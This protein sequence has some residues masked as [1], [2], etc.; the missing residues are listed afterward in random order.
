[1]NPSRVS[2]LALYITL[3]VW[4]RYA[5]CGETELASNSNVGLDAVVDK[6]D[7]P[8]GSWLPVPIPISNPTVGTGLQGVLLYL[9]PAKPGDSASTPNATSGLG[10]MYTSTDSKVV[11]LFHDDYFADD[12]YRFKALAGVGDLNLN[13]Y[14]FGDFIS[15]DKV[16]Y[17]I[18]PK[19]TFIE[20][21]RRLPWSNNGYLG[22]NHLYTS[23]ELK[24]HWK[25]DLE[26][27]RPVD[28]PPIKLQPTTSSLGLI[29][30]Y[31]SRDDTYYPTA[32]SNTAIKLTRDKEQWGS[33]FD[34]QRLSLNFRKY[35]ALWQKHVLA[36]RATLSDV[37]GKPPFYFL[38]SLPLRGFAAGRY[39]DNSSASLHAE[40][41]Y[42]YSQRWGAHF[43]T[44][45]G[46][47][48]DSFKALRDEKLISSF[49]V[50]L[51]WQPI[52]QKKLHLGI[53]VAYS[54]DESATYLRVGEA[55]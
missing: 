24:F 42:K 16:G 4:A 54:G 34:F 18:K 43:F 41:R 50:G 29:Y 13:F 44:E 37:D 5:L 32:G 23:A 49:G 36:V 26:G 52:V 53:D 21:S 19:I 35:I 47:I 6:N 22:I 30:T 40:W 14:G 11:G 20:A 9:H 3:M 12:K 7:A 2:L 28:F 17:N 10:V 33:D 25:W 46:K 27:G 31:D 39:L 1:M 45:A 8:K 48:S 51:R 55:F 38:S 15:G